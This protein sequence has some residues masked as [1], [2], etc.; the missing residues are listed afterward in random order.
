[1][2]A[3]FGDLGRLCAKFRQKF[4][5]PSAKLLRQLCKYQRSTWPIIDS[6]IQNKA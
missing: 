2:E 1:M 6:A 3:F 4:L 5:E